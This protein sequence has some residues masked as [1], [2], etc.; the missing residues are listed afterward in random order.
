MHDVAYYESM[1]RKILDPGVHPTVFPAKNS[2]IYTAVESNLKALDS[3]ALRPRV[4]IDVNQRD[5][6][7]EVLGQSVALPVLAAPIGYMTRYH[8]DA[9]LG[10]ARS[11]GAAGTIAAVSTVSSKSLESIAESAPG[12]LWFQLYVQKDRKLSENL[13][14][15]AR[16]AGYTAI[17]VTVDNSSV[18]RRQY[19]STSTRLD[20]S[21]GNFD[22]RVYPTR[23]MSEA[24]FRASKAMDFTWKDLAWLRSLTDLPVVLK[25]IQT[26]EDAALSEE[27]GVDAVIVSNHGGLVLPSSIGTLQMLPEVLEAVR[28][29]EV[30]IDGGIRSGQDVLKALAL[31][32]KAVL[33]G[34][35]LIW[36]L[37]VDGPAGVRRMF[38]TIR[39]ELELCM[40]VCG[41]TSAKSADV[42]LVPRLTPAA[43]FLP[44]LNRTGSGRGGKD[45]Q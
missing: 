2:S 39:D 15:R 42:R 24:D 41:V 31:G 22:P 37:S 5:T 10:V 36:A 13:V 3:V 1:A 27:F 28:R 12:P 21:L 45:L 25:G 4:M 43:G 34:R 17:V 20:R 11:A 44:V 19:D 16:D 6:S 8:T 29:T 9:E 18:Q 26:A 23:I 35:P 38:E 7:T 40:G 14:R 32:A 33:I 30:Y